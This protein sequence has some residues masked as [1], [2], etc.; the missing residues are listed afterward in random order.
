MPDI[1]VL[2]EGNRRI[3]RARFLVPP[4]TGV[5]TDPTAITFVARRRR[6]SGDVPADYAPT[7]YGPFTMGV[8]PTSEVSRTSGVPT[9]SFDFIFEP[10]QGTWAV[11]VKGTGAA[12][13]AG[14]IAFVVDRAE[15]LA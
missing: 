7:T 13:A 9:G 14:E 1:E 8:L 2:V 4:E 12:H 6:E 10:K 15:A 11:Y 5:L 3:V